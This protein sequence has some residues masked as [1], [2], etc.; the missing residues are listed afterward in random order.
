MFMGDVKGRR[1]AFP[2]AARPEDYIEV[3]NA[4]APFL[5]QIAATKAMFD[6]FQ[7]DEESVRGQGGPQ[8]DTGIGILPVGG[9]KWAA[10]DDR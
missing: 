4:A 3:E 1:F 7:Q 8:P 10:A 2:Y 5:P 6:R 9:A